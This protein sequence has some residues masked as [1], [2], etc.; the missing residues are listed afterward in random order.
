M[1]NDGIKVVI[2]FWRNDV[3][4]SELMQAVKENFQEMGGQ[5]VV[6]NDTRYEPRTGQLA[7]S[8]YRIN[9]A[10]WDKEL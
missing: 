2:P 5:L 9:F 1:W 10:L 7:A 6:D 4:G 3:Y 8:L